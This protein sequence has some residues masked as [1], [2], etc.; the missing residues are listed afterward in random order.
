[1]YASHV[2]ME[3]Q[4]NEMKKTIT[5]EELFSSR[6]FRDYLLDFAETLTG[7]YGREIQV[8]TQW[9]TKGGGAFT[10]NRIISINCANPIT[11]QMPNR[12]LKADSLLGL[13]SHEAAHILFTDFK[14]AKHYHNCITKGTLYPKLRSLNHTSP[15]YQEMMDY[16]QN[17]SSQQREAFFHCVFQLAN[18]LED[19]Y[20]ESRMVH[21]F[22]G[23]VAYG[24]Q[25]F[26]RKA[27]EQMPS[28]LEQVAEKRHGFTILCNLM[29]QYCHSG[30]INNFGN[31]EGEYMELFLQCVPILDEGMY[32]EKAVNRFGAANRLMGTIWKAA[33]EMIEQC[34]SQQQPENNAKAGG[35]QQKNGTKTEEPQQPEDNSK[36]G[37]QQQ[38]NGA[39]PEGQADQNPSNNLADVVFQVLQEQVNGTTAPQGN[40]LPIESGDIGLADNKEQKQVLEHRVL[41][42][43]KTE[44]ISVGTGGRIIKNLQYEGQN[45][46]GAAYGIDKILS[47]IGKER[48]YQRA[49]LDLNELLQLE[50]GRIRYGNAHKGIDIMLHRMTAVPELYAQQYHQIALP[51]EQIGT[52][53]AKLM[54][55]VLKDQKET[56]RLSGYLQGRKI[57]IKAAMQNQNGIFYR[58]KMPTEK[59]LTVSVLIDQSGSMA[60]TRIHMAQGA[61]IAVY[62]FCSMM[63][64]PVMITGH[65]YSSKKVNIYVH[66]D[67]DSVDKKDKYRLMDIHDSGC[68][69]DGAAI[70]YVAERLLR[71]PEKIKLLLLISDG[72]PNAD[73]YS[74]T[75][76]EADLRG[77]KREYT[78]KGI[79]FFAAAIGDDKT[80]IQR[81]YGKGYLDMTNLQLLP[82]NL[83]KLIS[84][85]TN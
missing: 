64:I 3:R 61:A 59:D 48:V 32:E 22:K 63:H 66:A 31:Y 30:D 8:A 67:F 54:A 76:A 38:G 56:G 35:Q 16:L 78:N 79:L 40:S 43:E 20:V 15:Y 17:A 12:K 53:M 74:G 55:Q 45:N 60:G 36:T 13:L 11:M 34:E 69:R 50:A 58:N 49:E 10:D 44:T 1:M 28:L 24:L 29:L 51:I 73:G 4:I 81:I 23:S 19:A 33:K 21:L 70:R 65:N 7:R 62:H 2:K 14:K 80:A 83:V 42:P 9:D 26:N 75:A 39:Q 77:I 72:L 52:R 18:I 25:L 82:K 37:R 84:K 85:Y 27:L 41:K 57:N 5:D 6:Q 47:E 46:Q 71:R 68:N